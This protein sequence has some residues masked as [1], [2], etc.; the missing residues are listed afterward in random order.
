MLEAGEFY[1]MVIP[2][3]PNGDRRKRRVRI[4]M[5]ALRAL[6]EVNMV[7]FCVF[8]LFCFF[9]TSNF[10]ASGWRTRKS[11]AFVLRVAGPGRLGWVATRW[12]SIDG[13]GRPKR[14]AYDEATARQLKSFRFLLGGS[15]V[16]HPYRK[17]YNP[18]AMCRFEPRHFKG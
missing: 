1:Q 13:D 7:S 15:L 4:K 16:Y 11:V 8:F 10:E 2:Y 14:T 6:A 3:P 12:N 18:G 17:G 5:W 9:F